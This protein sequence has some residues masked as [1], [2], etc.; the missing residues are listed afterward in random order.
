MHRRPRPVL[1]LPH[2]RDRAGAARPRRRR[3][4]AA[5]A[6]H[7]DPARPGGQRVRRPAGGPARR[8]PRCWACRR[9]AT[10][11]DLDAALAAAARPGD[12]APGP[13][14]GHR[15]RPG[16][17]GGRRARRTGRI[18]DLAPLLDAS[19]ASMRDDFEITV[20]TV[21]L[22]VEAAREAGALGSPD[23]RWRLRRLHHRP[24]AGRTV[25]TRWPRASPSA[26]PRPATARRSTSSAHPSAGASRLRLTARPR[27][28]PVP[29]G[30]KGATSDRRVEDRHRSGRA[31]PTPCAR[32]CARQRPS[33]S[34]ATTT[35]GMP[36]RCQRRKPVNV[37]YQS[38]ASPRPRVA[39]LALSACGSDSLSGEPAGSG[40]PSVSVSQD[41][42]LAAKL[43]REHQG[44]RRDQGRHRRQLCAR[45]VPGR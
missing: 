41:A 34:S 16:A 8:P 21:D 42:D 40:A 23:D 45:R 18:A 13:P 12:A 30:P 14:C 26:S 22:A 6:R 1:R 7:Q 15:E 33:A 10:S 17:G 11:T 36:R 39:A 43:P 2:L 19:H 37:T 32:R 24:G 29:T 9:C 35:P 25:P 28:N 27:S 44:R 4:G 20:P 38:S 31:G 3:A 5:G